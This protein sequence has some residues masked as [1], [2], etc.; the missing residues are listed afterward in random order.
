MRGPRLVGLEVGRRLEPLA[1][2]VAGLPVEATEVLWQ[3]ARQAIAGNTT[4]KCALD[5]ALHH[6]RRVRQGVAL[7]V[8]PARRDG[9]SGPT[10]R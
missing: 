9:R 10:S 1:S 6:A 3:A 2:A 4:A 8:L 7:A 5:L